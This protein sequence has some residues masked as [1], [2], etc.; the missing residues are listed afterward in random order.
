MTD[1]AKYIV[2]EE[3]ATESAIIF[4]CWILHANI[5]GEKKVISA[6]KV[7]FE[8]SGSTVVIYCYGESVGLKVKSRPKEDARLIEQ[9]IL[10][11]EE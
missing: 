8:L 4:P 10:R 1:P 11:M 7:E 2:I 9:T 5:A 3:N 6:G